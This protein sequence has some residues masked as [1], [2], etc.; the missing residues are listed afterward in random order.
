MWTHTLTNPGPS[1]RV[2]GSCGKLSGLTFTY[3]CFN[4]QRQILSSLI[5]TTTTNTGNKSLTS[6][7]LHTGCPNSLAFPLSVRGRKS[8][9]TRHG[10]IQC[11]VFTSDSARDHVAGNKDTSSCEIELCTV[12]E[13]NGR[14]HNFRVHGAG[15]EPGNPVHLS[16]YPTR[17]NQPLSH[18]EYLLVEHYQFWKGHTLMCYIQP[19]P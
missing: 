6:H 19:T 13:L 11:I 16:L 15:N 9:G 18:M 12:G 3:H 4:S 14:C 1:E 10:G 7:T 8:L 17:A 2:V 5:V